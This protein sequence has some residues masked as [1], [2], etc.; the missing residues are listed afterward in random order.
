MSLPHEQLRLNLARLEAAPH[1][2]Q[3]PPPPQLRRRSLRRAVRE[4]EPRQQRQ[5]RRVRRVAAGE[6][7]PQ[8]GRRLVNRL[9]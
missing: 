1:P 9:E 3:R 5:Q 6:S 7:I 2:S 8:L 4:G